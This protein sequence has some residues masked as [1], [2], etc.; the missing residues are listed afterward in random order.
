MVRSVAVEVG[1]SGLSR[2]G[3]EGETVEQASMGSNASSHYVIRTT[4]HAE[5]IVLRTVNTGTTVQS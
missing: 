3:L 2:I 1:A 4:H 5:N